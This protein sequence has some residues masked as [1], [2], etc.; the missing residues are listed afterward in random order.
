MRE[1]ELKNALNKIEISDEMQSRILLN[2]KNINYRKDRKY[3]K[4]KKKFTLIA[5]A[6]TLI[7][8]ITAAAATYIHRVNGIQSRMNISDEQMTE[9]QNTDDSPVSF[10]EVSDT[11]D[12]ITASVAQC[13]FDGNN[14]N[15]AF[16][17]KGYELDKSIE[18]KLESLDILIDDKPVNNYTWSFYNGIERDENNNPV[19]ADGSGAQED[20]RGRL[21]PNYRIA[22][23]KMEIDLTLFPVDENGKRIN[24]LEGKK[25]TVLM[26]N[27]GDKNG[28][29]SLEWILDK[30][31]NHK[32]ATPDAALGNSGA[33]V[34]S[35]T[36]YQTSATIY[37]DFPKKEIHDTG[38]DENGN[39]IEYTDFEEPPKFIG[40]KLTDGTVY[41][42]ISYGGGAYGYEDE[43][44]SV[45]VARV[46]LSRVIDP[47]KVE[48]I[49][50]LKDES[51]SGETPVTEEDCYVVNIK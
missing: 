19:M 24:D 41:T 3:M 45:F 15:I 6:A 14:I 48:S 46:N 5:V 33:T 13:L 39:T 17:V 2:A 38:F 28:T 25:I 12:G 51:V 36:L 4:S 34:T 50:F 35:V 11:H 1:H 9:L 23:G 8:G 40:V 30:I 49:L 22:D 18:P 43:E 32:D 44:A 42:D 10:P 31:N 37:Y 7:L 20:S 16:Y 26:Q 47:E 29:W 21:I 27:F